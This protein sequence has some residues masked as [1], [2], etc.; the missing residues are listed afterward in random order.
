VFKSRRI[1]IVI[2]ALTVSVTSQYVCA[3]DSAPA[4]K[5]ALSYLSVS[6]IPSAEASDVLPKP[7]SSLVKNNTSTKDGGFS[8][9]QAQL[10]R[11]LS[12]II[13]VN[14]TSVS[15]AGSIRFN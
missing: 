13:I 12:H 6:I 14:G 8:A 5:G 2:V 3:D 7:D 1:I 9:N 10:M 11:D 4:P 15:L